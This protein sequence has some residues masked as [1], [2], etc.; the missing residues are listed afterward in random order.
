MAE[1]TSTTTPDLTLRPPASDR[2]GRGALMA[3]LAHAALLIGLSIAVHWR[4]KPEPQGM[5]AELWSAT[6]K[7]AAPPAPP[8]QET[9]VPPP[10]TPEP[11]I[12]P[13]A[14]PPPSPSPNEEREA[15]IALAK[16]RKVKEA[17]MKEAQL[18]AQRE[19]QAKR[20]EEEKKRAEREAEQA[21]QEKQA[22]QLAQQQR[23]EREA[24][25]QKAQAQR[26]K[27][28]QDALKRM[29][30]SLGGEGAPNST[31]KDAHN[32]GLSAGYQGRIRARIKPNI[33]YTENIDD[34]PTTE[35]EVRTSPEGTIIGRR[36]VRSSGLP[37]WDEAVLRAIDKTEILPKNEEGRV[38]SPIT[39][40]FTP[41]DL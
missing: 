27:I 1:Q 26:E 39:I 20:Q 11:K 2:I 40:T 38:P 8:P 28:R 30:A 10:P 32:A 6:P 24:Q 25:E 34:N 35:I 31:G 41:R 14:P 33:T 12:E 22:Q 19:E 7:I 4:T 37:S 23:K 29:Q 15:E 18:K 13:K 9:P 36:I 16:E 3:L 17:Q 21:K 5:E